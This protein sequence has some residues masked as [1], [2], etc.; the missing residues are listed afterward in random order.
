MKIATWNVNSIRS[1]KELTLKWLKD[2]KPD[3][4]LLQETKCLDEAFPKEEFEDLGYNIAIFGQKTFN[5]VAILSLH[6]IEDVVRGFAGNPLEEHAR[7][8]EAVICLPGF[9]IRVASVYVPNGESLDSDKYQKKLKFFDMINEH[10]KNLLKQEEI[11]VIGGDF[12]VAPEEI[13]TYSVDATKD[14]V[15]FNLEIRNKLRSMINLGLYDA[16]RLKYPNESQFSWW[17][18]RGGA[19]H[20]NKGLRIDH[21][22]ISPEAADI[23]GDVEIDSSM[24]AKDSPSDHV[25]VTGLFHKQ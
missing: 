9:A 24:R 7:Y 1:R 6:P 5:G 20:K 3:V 8:I 18:Y 21:L 25:P 19:W 14:T 23:L 2:N 17:D 4:L 12:N 15:L 16:F 22:L 11:L 10:F 13:D